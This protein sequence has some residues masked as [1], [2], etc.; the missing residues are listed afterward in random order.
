MLALDSKTRQKQTKHALARGPCATT[1]QHPDQQQ[2]WQQR[3]IG[4]AL[5][6]RGS[7]GVCK[8]RTQH[9]RHLSKLARGVLWARPA[10]A[11]RGGLA[12]G[13]HILCPPRQSLAATR[14]RNRPSGPRR[15]VPFQTPSYVSMYARRLRY[16]HVRIS[17][18]RLALGESTPRVQDVMYAHPHSA[19]GR[20]AQQL[21]APAAPPCVRVGPPAT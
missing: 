21:R 12:A 7:S 5:A 11:P 15:R 19:G 8:V 3:H 17:S 13:A 10:H 16:A 2:Q 6:R 1:Q 4:E 18:C 14:T 9:A 20:R